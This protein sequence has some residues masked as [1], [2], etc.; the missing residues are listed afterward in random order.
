MLKASLEE[1]FG[2]G[3]HYKISRNGSLMIFLWQS[4]KTFRNEDNEQVPH[5]ITRYDLEKAGLGMFVKDDKNYKNYNTKIS[6]L[7][8]D[9]APKQAE[10]FAEE[11]VAPLDLD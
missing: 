3:M 7:S 9:L 11:T 2:Q 1:V 5:S 8:L 10:I 4:K 6:Y